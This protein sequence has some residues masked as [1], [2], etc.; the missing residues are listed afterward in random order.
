M[1]ITEVA[2]CVGLQTPSHFAMIFRR[3]TGVTPSAYRM[4]HDRRLRAR[5][6]QQ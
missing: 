5:A 4:A 1:P 6:F 3:R 2:S